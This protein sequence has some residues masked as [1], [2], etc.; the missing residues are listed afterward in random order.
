MKL[1]TEPPNLIMRDMN[2]S[3]DQR[4]GINLK[5]PENQ[6]LCGDY[7]GWWSL[8]GRYENFS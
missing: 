1:P 4:N 6:H 7:G 5:S 2:H 3:A 8:S